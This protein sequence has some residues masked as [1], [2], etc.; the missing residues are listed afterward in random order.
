MAVE[1]VTFSYMN[2]ETPV[3]DDV[4]AVFPAG[5]MTAI[6]GATG[7]GKT[8]LGYL[9]AR[10]YDPDAGRVT[11]DGIDVRELAPGALAG[12]VGVVS[13]HPYLFHASIAENLRFAAPE[14]TDAQLHAACATAQVHD[15]IMSLP[16]AYDTLVGER[17]HRF[18]GG[19]QQRLALARTLLADPRV[20]VL[21]E[22]T[23]ALDN[24]TERAVHAALALDRTTRKCTTIAI[25][26]RLSTVTDADQILVM[27][28]GAIVERGTHAELIARAGRYAVLARTAESADQAA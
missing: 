27:D 20:L 12:A 16:K 21:D 23:S 24:A 22:A 26:H 3:V 7:S 17:G 11:L 18:S 28:H 15:L 2:A 14:A 1:G 19:E 10:L 25:A 4:A 6:V 5:S 13:Q 9:L 8:T